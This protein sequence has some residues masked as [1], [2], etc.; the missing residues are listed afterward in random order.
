MFRRG[1]YFSEIYKNE[2][3]FLVLEAFG[4]WTGN[5]PNGKYPPKI[6]EKALNK[7]EITIFEDKENKVKKSIEEILLR[8]PSRP[9]K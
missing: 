5:A 9:L 2:D 7:I 8:Y 3:Y 1:S 4:S 6:N